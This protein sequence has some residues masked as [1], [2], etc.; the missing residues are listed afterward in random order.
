MVVCGRSQLPQPSRLVGMSVLQLSYSCWSRDMLLCLLRSS[1]SV[2]YEKPGM[3]VHTGPSCDCVVC[4]V[5]IQ[6][7]ANP[8]IL[9]LKLERSR[10]VSQ[11]SLTT[12]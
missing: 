7:D 12:L 10:P 11:I 3:H 4:D 1:M 6:S 2:S 8:M 9:L 5:A